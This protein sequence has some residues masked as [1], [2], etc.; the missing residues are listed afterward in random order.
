MNKKVIELLKDELGRKI[1]KE[2]VALRAKTYACKTDDDDEKKKAT[3]T[4]KCVIKRQLMFK[5]YKYCLFSG[6]VI[7]KSQQIFKSDIIKCT[8]KKLIRLR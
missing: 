1:M 6:K 3:G 2:F 5:N 7:L 8:Q 4:K